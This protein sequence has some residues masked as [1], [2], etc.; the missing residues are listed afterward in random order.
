MSGGLYGS[1]FSGVTGIN[2]QGAA[3]GDISNNVSNINTVGY[4][5]SK[6]SF[7]SLVT[8][9]GSVGASGGGAQARTRQ[10]IDAQGLI[11]PTGVSTDLAI[12]GKGFFVVNDKDDGTGE[13]LYTRAG[14]FRT[15]SRGNLQNAA[16]Y[17][18]QAWP[19]DNEARLPGQ[20]GN[21]NTTPSSRLDS[22]VPVNTRGSTVA[23]ATT[24]IEFGLN[25]DAGETRLR[26]RGAVI[27]FPTA[28][29]DFNGGPDFTSTSIIAPGGATSGLAIGD[30]FTVRVDGDTD[31]TFTYGGFAESVA[32]T[33]GI[34]GATTDTG[35]FTI[36]ATDEG[37]ILR[38]TAASLPSGT[39]EFTLSNSPDPL[40]GR[41]DS[42]A[43]LVEAINGTTGLT[44]RII[45]DRLYV[46]SR[47]AND[48][49]TFTN[50]DGPNGGGSVDFTT[51]FFAQASPYTIAA[52]MDRFNTLDGLKNV[53]ETKPGLGA[54]IESTTNDPR[55]TIFV[56]D[57]LAT[58]EFLDVPPSNFIGA[59]DEFGIATGA[60]DPLYN[61]LNVGGGNMASGTIAPQF[62]R[63]VRIFDGLGVGHDF[64]LS[65]VKI[66]NNQWAVEI[67]AAEP[68]EIVST[69]DDGLVANGTITFNGDGS[70]RNI[71]SGLLGNIEVSWQNEAIISAIELDFGTAGQPLGT[72]G[73]TEIGLT[74]GLTQFDG[75]YD[76]RFVDQNGAGAG[77]LT[78]VNVDKDGF[79]FFNYSNGESRRIYKI[80]LADFPNLNGLTSTSGNAYTQGDES[81]D[82]TLKEAG[83]GG[84][85]V[86]SPE[87]LE[88]SGTELS[89]ELTD[90]IVAQRSYEANTKII[91]TTD[92]LLETLTQILR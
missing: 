89:A 26:G 23:Q 28:T 84:V 79:L 6:S 8:G 19:L 44:A 74:D 55:M 18:L 7:S 27:E 75:S 50:V 76:V 66:D 56:E 30:A 72:E 92:G 40:N 57:P 43:T 67:Y 5:T 12:S 31:V 61:A 64:R 68:A 77:L 48:A 78:S 83:D 70:L 53:I 14:S 4:K 32:V 58:I 71:S 11:L 42:L 21:L 15:D 16:G 65:A 2:V 90:L 87:S 62:S 85:G 1:L 3:I 81:G 24:K 34:I 46:S 73:A 69:R 25:L 80:P 37:D 35:S 91:T 9:G 33:T 52:G 39:A 29:G 17:Y 60:M 36:G 47:D 10:A 49:I 59:G 20:L 13:V 51:E 41:F 63:N 54:Q 88:N 82:F 86:F 22:L 38:I 45:N